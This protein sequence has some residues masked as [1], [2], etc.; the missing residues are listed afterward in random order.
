MRKLSNEIP[1]QLQRF[2]LIFDSIESVERVQKALSIIHE[3]MSE[4][5]TKGD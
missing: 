2:T 3:S 1:K 5:K 4:V